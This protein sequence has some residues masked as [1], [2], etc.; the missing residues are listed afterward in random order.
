LSPE[1]IPMTKRR[2]WSW[3]FA[4]LL[5]VACAAPEHKP[6]TQSGANA[7]AAP[8]AHKPRQP[9]VAAT[10]GLP[11]RAFEL[12]THGQPL[13]ALRLLAKELGERLNAN[14]WSDPQLVAESVIATLAW[15]RLANATNAWDE[16]IA[17]LESTKQFA[18]GTPPELASELDLLLALGLR[19]AG[20]VTE[21]RALSAGRGALTDWLVI[22]PFAN[23]RGGGFD[24]K[25]APEEGID[26]DKAVRGKERDVAWRANPAQ[27]HPLGA[28]RLDEMLRPADQA[29]AYLATAVRAAT[30]REVVLHV[31]S[32]GAVKVFLDDVE[33][34]AR[35]VERPFH[36]DQDRVVLAL[37]PGW[38]RVLVKTGVEE[39]QPWVFCARLTEL[40][41]SPLH[42]VEVDSKQAARAT[43]KAQPATSSPAP[44]AAELL[45]ARDGDAEAAR[46]LALYHLSI[47]PDDKATHTARIWAEKANALEPD[48][49]QGLYLLALTNAP[50]QGATL[51]EAQI[52]AHLFPLKDVLAHDPRHVAALLD[53]A[54]FAIDVNPTPER[55]DALTSEALAAAPNHWRSMSLR[56]KLLDQRGRDA[57]AQM[58]RERAR[59]SEEGRLQTSAL[60]AHAHELVAHGELDASLAELKRGFDHGQGDDPLVAA[61]VAALIDRNDIAGAIDVTQ[62]QLERAPFDVDRLLVTAQLVEYAGQVPQARELVEHALR[63]CPERMQAHLALARL[64]QR[65]GDLA[66]AD[67]ELAEVMRLE[68]GYDKA[69]RQ[70]QIL[71]TTV[72]DRFE[73]PYRWD[74]LERIDP[75]P[76]ESADNDPVSV[77]DRT[78]V[79]RV[80]A[81]GTEHMYEHLL[82]RA[83]NLGGVK[84]LDDYSIGYASDASLQV[85]NVR[86]IRRDKTF[87]RAPAPRR[88]DFDYGEERW[89]PF[90]LPPIEVGDWVDLEYRVDQSRPD[91][92]GQYFGLRYEFYA[93]FPDAL[94]PV[95]RSELVVIAPPDVPLYTTERKPELLEQ[96][97]QND[98]QGNVVYRWVA[99][100]L[101]RPPMQSAMP[102]RSEFAP[103][104]DVSTFESWEAFASWWWNFIEKEFVTTPAMKQKVKELTAGLTSE[105]DKVRA[106]ARFVGQEIRY[107]AWPFGTHGYEPYSAAT[108]FERRF[109][110]C[111]DKS[112]LLRQLLAEIGVDA[113]PVLLEARAWRPKEFLDVAM[114]GAFNHCIAYV[115]ATAQ[116]GGYY[117]D[118]TADRNPIEY[119]RA[120]DQGATVLHVHD[121]HGAVQTIP[122]APP[123]QNAL[124][125]DYDVKLDLEGGG[126]VGLVDTSNGEYGVELR[127]RFGGEKGDLNKRLSQ[128]LADEFGK[129]D[130]LESSTSNLEDIGTAPRVEAK[131]RSRGLWSRDAAGANLRLGFDAIPLLSIASESPEERAFDLV[132]DRPFAMQTR[133][134]YRLPPGAKVA[135]LPPDAAVVAPG[136]LE[137]HMTAR[138]TSDGIE[139]HRD[140][141]LFERRVGKE[142]YADFRGA[143]RDVELAESR[144]IVIQPAVSDAQK[145][146]K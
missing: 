141:K 70:R 120:D 60:L 37:Q 41:G 97:K 138:E 63:I 75:K 54:D 113:Y 17:A 89:R 126:E 64:A 124:V 50:E 32:S 146:G 3:Q 43:A 21:A 85:Y 84:S 102:P 46:M 100:D 52:N 57:E 62:R 31:G 76:I 53:L 14:A 99:R 145:G 81:D 116:R 79:W 55:A 59:A 13:E 34:L 40:D 58:L 15:E 49:V 140:F 47:H 2:S 12:E 107:N 83:Q 80:N 143:L 7:A 125:R 72:Q 135:K 134:L 114:I 1:E 61:L 128:A 9:V 74:A 38:N 111:K 132:L 24:T 123:E 25:Y 65:D 11:R 67:R 101:K 66:T 96:S 95:A 22:G 142:R 90:D 130:V 144:T 56:A 68:P 5:A 10:P 73:T 121:G 106:I 139:V 105:S 19:G 129:V 44:N 45:A 110:D 86:V 93:D 71:A 8:V 29:V 18:A 69:R 28:L 87:E 26:V 103:A 42:G 109:G 104:V 112:I 122:Y 77:V 82:L 35:K 92:F 36:P 30:P 27:E 119:L 6:A 108:I 136:L 115:P 118:A 98:A 94:A 137:Y 51:E 33:V 48:D 16:T 4:L 117:L 23:E 39:K 88:G 133:V 20:R 131:I 91:V 127:Y 78:T